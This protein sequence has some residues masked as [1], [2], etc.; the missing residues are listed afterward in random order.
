MNILE[1]VELYALMGELYGIW[2]IILSKAAFKKYS[3]ETCQKNT[4]GS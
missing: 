2:Y 4:E 1:T 3:M